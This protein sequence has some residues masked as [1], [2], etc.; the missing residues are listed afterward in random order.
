MQK[1]TNSVGI[2]V[3]PSVF[4]TQLLPNVSS[5]AEADYLI[6]CFLELISG[7]RVL[8]QIFQYAKGSMVNKDYYRFVQKE[9][10]VL[11]FYIDELKIKKDN[12]KG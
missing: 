8:F 6:L 10:Q 9:I 3:P 12:L 5:T 11:E 7:Y 4:F 2:S 1:P